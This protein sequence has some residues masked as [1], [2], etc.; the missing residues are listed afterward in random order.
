M[1]AY[2]MKLARR[3]H[4]PILS[5]NITFFGFVLG[6]AVLAEFFFEGA[7]NLIWNSANQ[8]RLVSPLTTATTLTTGSP[9]QELCGRAEEAQEER[10]TRWMVPYVRLRVL[11]TA[12]N[13]RRK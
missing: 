3:L 9:G 11:A 12:P 10:L 4:K 7:T 6:G 5:S 1:S 13:T 2:V 8:V